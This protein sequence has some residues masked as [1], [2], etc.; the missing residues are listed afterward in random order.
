MFA[1]TIWVSV[2]FVPV[3][4]GQD[5][6]RFENFSLNEGLSQ[7]KVRAIHQDSEGFMWFGTQEGLNRF[8]GY[9]FKV[10]SNSLNDASSIGSS[11]INSIA[12]TLD[13]RLWFATGSG[14]SVL[15]KTDQTFTRYKLTNVDGETIASAK[16]IF[17]DSHDQVW[18]GTTGG[19]FLYDYSKLA[20]EAVDMPL[21]S[22]DANII[23]SIAEDITAGLWIASQKHGLYRYDRLNREV[24][25]YTKQVDASHKSGHSNVSTLM[26]DSGQRL[27][28]GTTGNG[29]YILD[30]KKP[31]SSNVTDNFEKVAQFSDLTIRT[32]YQDQAENVWVGTDT[33][34]YVFNSR[35]DKLEILRYDINNPGSLADDRVTS[36]YQDRGGVFWVG[37]YRGLSKWNTA[38]A[39]FDYFRI[40]NDKSKS[41]SSPNIN[42]IFNGGNDQVWIGTHFGLNLLD[43]DD[44]SIQQ[45]YADKENAN[46]IT[47]NN[48]TSIYAPNKTSVVLG[49]RSH[50]LS[51]YDRESA[52]FTHYRSDRAKADTIGSDQI[53]SILG[54]QAGEI[55][56]G[57]FKGGLNYFD[58]DAGIF[59]RHMNDPNNP[60]S[61]SSNMVM[62]I[63]E[64]DQEMLWVGT[65]D[66]GLNLFNPALNT[67]TRIMHDDE[68]PTSLGSNV[69]WAVHED[70]QGNI[71][72]GT[73][74]AGLNYLSTEN[75]KLGNYA[76]ERFSR[77]QGLPSSSVYSILEDN[78]G[79][80]WLSTNRG[81]TK[82]NPRTKTMLNYDSSHGLQGNEFNFGAYHKMPDGQFFFGGTNG[83][84]AFYPEHIAPNAHVPPVVLTKFQ[85]LNEVSSMNYSA[86]DSNRIEVSHKDYLI[87]FEFAGLDFASPV[88]NR[89]AYKL[90]GFDKEWIEARDIRKA[91]YTNLP[92]G[93]Y[94]FK[95]KASNNDGIWNEEGANIMLTVLPAPWFS[96]WAYTIYGM[97]FLIITFLLYRSYLNKVKREEV[98]LAQLENEV[99]KRTMELSAANEQLLNASVTDQLTG[100]HNRRYLANVIKGE[101][102]KVQ[103]EFKSYLAD[104]DV[105]ANEGPRLFFL[106]FDLDGFKPINDT[107]GHDAGDRVIIQVG[108]LLQ[109]VCREDD[110]VIRWGG[111]EFM[112]VGKVLDQGEV[113]YLAERIR[114]T[115]EKYGFNIGL[116]QRMHLSSSIGYA[117]YPFAHFSPD[118]LS[119][120]QVHLLADKALY[121][122]KDAGRNTWVGMVQ[123][124][125]MPAVGVMNTLTHNVDNA[126]ELGHI[127]LETPDTMKNAHKLRGNVSSLASR[128]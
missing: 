2:S 117:M 127:I 84:T 101:C 48:V 44:G 46:T 93:N 32:L 52:T 10:Y 17:V 76:F 24:T 11:S 102:D 33:G 128:K 110:I 115:I 55:W 21:M 57:A 113:S 72:V 50:G 62:S 100:L 95:V 7:E 68:D 26:F 98:Y 13:G 53:T 123:C 5:N 61:L 91:T 112:V 121:K 97:T 40:Q 59:R 8:D 30:L 85:R 75:R 116:S 51:V 42:A 54:T 27:W 18:V 82:F 36:L 29:V 90:E 12:E 22:S 81:L 25:L 66:K 125:E 65:Y 105:Y 4:A 79:M 38:T 19:L 94:I 35:T 86:D 104:N 92:A 34:L 109:S 71:W 16:E 20:F 39:K 111:D 77:E 31:P 43:L 37:T 23:E 120:E 108:E 60:F 70:K 47:D 74:G 49:Y 45:Y 6:I 28:V 124:P 15:N 107:Y 122:S 118:S 3:Y 9:Q 41:L 56:I 69:V 1:L 126:V 89:Y 14:V 119:W 87:A 103:K 58:I 78:E 73:Q 88:N 106:M 114:E 83:V 67:A 80:L 63:Y 64:D 99:Q 96:W